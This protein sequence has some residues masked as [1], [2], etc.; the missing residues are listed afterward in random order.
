[1]ARGTAVVG[2]VAVLVVAAGT[3]AAGSARAA[4]PPRVLHLRFHRVISAEPEDIQGVLVS[5]QYALVRRLDRYGLTRYLVYDDARGKSWQIDTRPCGS[6]DWPRNPPLHGLGSFGAPWVMFTCST[7]PTAFALYNVVNRR[8]RRITGGSDSSAFEDAAA[9]EIGAAWI[10]LTYAGGQDCGDDIHFGCGESYRFYNIRSRRLRS[11][12]PMTSSTV[13][14]LDSP[15]LVRHLCKPVQAPATDQFDQ[16]MG[17][18]ALYGQFAIEFAPFDVGFLNNTAPEFMAPLGRRGEW[19]LQRCGSSLRLSIDAQNQG[20]TLGAL[21]A[22]RH[23]V[24]WSVVKSGGTWSGSIAG[25]FLP[26]LRPFVATVPPGVAARG[27]DPSRPPVDGA[28]LDSSRIYV[29]DAAGR[30]LWR[31]AFP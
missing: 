8:W 25:R 11:S 12:P 26:S 21:T 17:A 3:V 15:R 31:A 5:K 30:T 27:P 18:L 13:F 23:A 14:D 19:T 9:F 2:L 28:V 4:G 22:N 7:G 10:K 20:Q 6:A 16:P 1:M 29:I 24:L